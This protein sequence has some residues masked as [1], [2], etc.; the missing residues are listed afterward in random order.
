MSLSKPDP[1][2]RYYTPRPVADACLRRLA[3][4]VGQGRVGA[5]EYVDPS[6]GGGVWLEAAA[7]LDPRARCVGIDVDPGAPGRERWPWLTADWLT[8]QLPEHRGPSGPRYIVGNPPFPRER[9]AR[10]HVAHALQ[11]VDVAA[12]G[13]VLPVAYVGLVGWQSL[14]RPSTGD[15]V[16]ASVS[17]ILGRPWTEV[18]EVAWWTWAPR[19]HRAAECGPRLGEGISWR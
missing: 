16:L 14:I 1:L 13:M 18:R 5:P 17:P 2:G 8:L 6:A 15:L 12:V 7:A 11:Q 19:R 9:V 10:Q 4:E 3:A